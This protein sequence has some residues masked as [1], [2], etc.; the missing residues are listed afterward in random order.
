MRGDDEWSGVLF[1]YID[2][3]ARV[4]RD[5]PLRV[6]REIANAALASLAQ[7]FVALYPGSGVLDP[8]RV[9]AQGYAAAGALFDPFGAADDGAAGIRS[10]VSL[11]RRH[12]D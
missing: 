11:A 6:I 5:H 1:S 4:W 8:I 9:A 2:L 12:R 3:E 10:V 7:D